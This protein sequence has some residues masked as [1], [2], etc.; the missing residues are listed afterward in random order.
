MQSSL[1]KY[2]GKSD[3]NT[4]NW[5][6]KVILDVIICFGFGNNIE[7]W[8]LGAWIVNSIWEIE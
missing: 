8:A 7:N 6:G 5:S 1:F 4:K 3:S 2:L